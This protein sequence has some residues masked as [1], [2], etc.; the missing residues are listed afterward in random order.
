MRHAQTYSNAEGTWPND[1]DPINVTGVAQAKDASR[2]V[3]DIL[4]NVVISSSSTRAV[5]TA[6]IVCNGWYDGKIISDARFKEIDK[7]VENISSFGNRVNE[8]ISYIKN[9][10]YGM[11]TLVVTHA[12]FIRLFFDNNNIPVFEDEE[13]LKNCS[14]A[15][16]EYTEKGWMLIFRYNANNNSLWRSEGL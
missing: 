5:Q 8:D 10:M 6:Q 3:K 12:G 9:N 15:G 2:I 7:G 11:K 14:I 16:F 13:Y 4:P 1:D